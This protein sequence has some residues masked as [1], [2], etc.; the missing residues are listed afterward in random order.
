MGLFR[1]AEAFR[2]QKFVPVF[3]TFRSQSHL[4]SEVRLYY[5]CTGK[6]LDR[7]V[8]HAVDHRLQPAI[9]SGGTCCVAAAVVMGHVARG[10]SMI[11]H[12]AAERCLQSLVSLACCS[13]AAP[14]GLA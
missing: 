13:G 1:W 2:G 12:V 11:R 6:D 10:L 4:D 7:A 14:L 9:E 5:L 3:E 8:Q